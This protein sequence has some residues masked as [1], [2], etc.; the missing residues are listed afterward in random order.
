MKS[1]YLSLKHLPENLPEIYKK[2]HSDKAWGRLEFFLDDGLEKVYLFSMEYNL[3]YFVNW[4]LDMHLPNLYRPCWLLLPEKQSISD[5]ISQPANINLVNSHQYTN[6][7]LAPISL[8]RAF[9]YFE[10]IPRILISRRST[11]NGNPNEGEISLAGFAY[12]RNHFKIAIEE[13]K[14][15]WAYPFDLR[16]YHQDSRW[17]LIQF[18]EQWAE[19]APTEESKNEALSI[20]RQ[21]LESPEA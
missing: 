15:P 8:K 3:I 20:F 6:V 19:I 10:P 17:E 5:F 4:Y 1:L 11:E 13:K 18:L 9:N 16:Q 12:R 2:S 7:Y 21:M 14:A